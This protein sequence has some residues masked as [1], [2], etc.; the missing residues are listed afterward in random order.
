L[1][2]P[3][4][5]KLDLRSATHQAPT[6][7]RPSGGSRRNYAAAD[8]GRLWK[9]WPTT[10]GTADRDLYMALAPMRVRS[11]HLAKNNDY[12][13]RFFNMLR[14]NVVGPSGIRLQFVSKDDAGNLDKFDNDLLEREWKNWGKKGV[15]T[16]DG[17][18]SFIDCQKLFIETVAR[19]GEAM[20][21]KHTG[22]VAR[23]K[24]KFAL[25]FIEPDL[26]DHEKNQTLPNGGS[27]RL[28]VEFDQWRRPVA[29]HV[30]RRTNADYL[31]S[32]TTHYYDRHDRIPASE[33]IHEF[34]VDRIGQS[35]GVPWMHT[36][37]RRL[38]MLNGY[39]E[40]ELV[41][42]RTAAAKMGFFKNEGGEDYTGDEDD[43]DDGEKKAPV[44]DAAAGTFEELPQGWDFVKWD[45]DHPVAAYEAF[46]LAILRGAA[47]GL[48]VSYVG[49]ANDL[50]GVSFSSIRQGTQE[51]RDHWRTLQGWTIEHFLTDVQESWLDAGLTLGG[52]TLPPRKFDKF[53]SVIWRPRGW[54][55]VNP[56]QEGTAHEKA[57][58]NGFKS[59]QDIAA[60]QGRDLEEIF[61]QI[62]AA[63][64]LAEKF[65]LS[66]DILTGPQ[67][68][69]GGTL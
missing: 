8:A 68:P 65:G 51:E 49:L 41:A 48:N 13:K 59:P 19:D 26:L 36:A 11:R 32:E 25:E 24:Y 52:L 27:I 37:A 39:E 2:T 61:E 15:C 23:N 54:Q 7:R 62:A 14:T 10:G 29:Y 16:V 56:A 57:V 44:M 4:I 9:D 46:V 67:Q 28:G 17:K 64:K 58:K 33:I 12:A 35:R 20:V 1:K 60:D 66:I 45:P 47:S 69:P 38:Q 43:E 21:R 42:S 53:N 5:D 6:R 3:L 30:K 34:L 55:W 31:F 40:A 50:R 18:L 22:P 63:K